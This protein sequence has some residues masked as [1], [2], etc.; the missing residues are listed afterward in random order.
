[1]IFAQ[2]SLWGGREESHLEGS[3]LPPLPGYR[4]GD[5]EKTLVL[6]IRKGCHF[7]EESLPFYK[8]LVELEKSN[9]LHAHVLAVM[10]DDKDSASK[11]LQSSGAVV[12]GIFSQPLDSLKVSGTP[13]LLLLDSKGRVERAWI[14]QLNPQGEKELIAT[15]EK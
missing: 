3:T 9:S 14:G 4:F 13:T 12:D 5:H 11:A 1:L 15:V 10:P 8:R 7:C 6:A 2:S